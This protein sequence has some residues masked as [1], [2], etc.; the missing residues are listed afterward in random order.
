[1][2]LYIVNYC[3][4]FC[5]PMYSITRLPEGEAYAKARELAVNEGT[6]FG[7]F[8]DFHNYYPRRI[9]T[10][11][12][13]YDHFIGLGGEPATDHP[14]YFV[15][16]GSDYLSDW[17]EKG[18]V[19]RLSLNNI[20]T[21]H[22][23]F[24]FGDSMAKMDKPERQDPFTKETLYGLIEAHDGSVEGFMNDIIKKCHY[25][26]AQLWDDRYCT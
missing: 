5:S 14:L 17:F 9:K 11:K 23:S 22:I 3:N 12:W 20:S 7:R 1:M 10:E 15:L 25:I 19:T 8:A 21:K 2:D 24:T 13:L 16:Q 26:E 6:S 4:P 18:T